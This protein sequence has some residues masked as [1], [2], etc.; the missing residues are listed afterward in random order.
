L[1]RIIVFTAFIILEVV[2]SLIKREVKMT[3]I[4]DFGYMGVLIF[5]YSLGMGYGIALVPILFIVRMLV[6]G[7]EVR[8]LIRSITLIVVSILASQFNAVNL[9]TLSIVLF[10]L[11][12]LMIHVFFLFIEGRLPF[13]K[14]PMQIVHGGITI[15]LIKIFGNLIITLIL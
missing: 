11:K 6:E 1:S 10:I 8:H 5:S 2:V 13:E 12:T 9:F 15:F 4:G 3:S 14:I 7:P